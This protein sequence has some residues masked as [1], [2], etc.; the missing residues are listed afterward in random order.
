V[1]VGIKRARVLTRTEVI[2][3]HAEATLNSY[4]EAGL[5]G[6]TVN[7]EYTTAGDNKVCPK[8]R[9]LEGKVYTIAEARGVIPMHPNCRCAWIGVVIDPSGVVLR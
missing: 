6:V 1:D 9:K 8:R 2:N 4:T 3:A 7:A 5:E